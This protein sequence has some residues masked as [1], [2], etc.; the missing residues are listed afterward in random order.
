VKKITSLP[1]I[2]RLLSAE[3]QRSRA[4]SNWMGRTSEGRSSSSDAGISK[5]NWPW[6]FGRM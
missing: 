3:S 6:A 2:A 4:T 1:A 5:V